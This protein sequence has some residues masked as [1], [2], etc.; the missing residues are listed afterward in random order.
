MYR[1]SMMQPVTMHA[2]DIRR[3]STI[4]MRMHMSASVSVFTY[5]YGTNTNPIP[6][7]MMPRP[8]RRSNTIAMDPG[9]YGSTGTPT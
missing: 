1:Q 8:K 7:N 2:A 4:D 3:I 5:G 9:G 6:V